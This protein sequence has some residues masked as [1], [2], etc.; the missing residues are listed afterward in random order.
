MGLLNRSNFLISGTL[1]GSV[2]EEEEEV[3]KEDEDEEEDEE[4]LY[5]DLGNS[6]L[7]MVGL[8]SLLSD[9]SEENLF[10]TE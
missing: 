4:D 1:A 5:R 10:L 6:G 2:L 7:T 8:D 9:M 3:E